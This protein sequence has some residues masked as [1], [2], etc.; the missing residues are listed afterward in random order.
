MT[1][2][3]DLNLNVTLIHTLVGM[4]PPPGGAAAGPSN[5][6]VTFFPFI[7]IIVM[8]YFL[9]I[10]PQQ[11]RAKEHKALLENLKSG[12]KVLTAGGIYGIVTNVKDKV[13]T[14]RIAENVKVD[15]EKSSIGTVVKD[16]EPAKA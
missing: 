16:E 6:L 10:R 8:F 15:V 3:T 2:P 11:K 7:I 13:I 4:A 14:V 5:P 1:L 12:D 9:L